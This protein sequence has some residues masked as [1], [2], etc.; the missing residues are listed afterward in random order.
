MDCCKFFRDIEKNP[1]KIVSGLKVKE[2]YEAKEHLKI[3]HNCAELSKK[4]L[5]QTV[6]EE[7]II[8]LSLN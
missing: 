7:S 1:D 5:A 6:P 2:Y 3:Y 4:V 8:K